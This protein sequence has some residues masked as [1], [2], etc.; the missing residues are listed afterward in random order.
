[1]DAKYRNAFQ[2][3]DLSDINASWDEVRS[4]YKRKVQQLHPDRVLHEDQSA[5]NQDE[6]IRVTRAYKLLNEY[7]RKNDDLPRDYV[8]QADPAMRVN[9]DEFSKVN[10]VEL[11]SVLAS[12]K[13]GDQRSLTVLKVVVASCLLALFCAIGI[14]SFAQW[15][16]SQVPPVT[17]FTTEK[18]MP[19]TEGN[20]TDTEN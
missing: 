5:A 8:Q 17:P 18:P 20:Q 15:Q 6:F 19:L 12:I 9:L 11:A 14:L 4:S 10:N 7:H 2:E 1:M 13:Y 16:K 3:L